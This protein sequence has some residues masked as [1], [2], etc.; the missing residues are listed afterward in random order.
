MQTK[1]YIKTVG[2]DE[3][4][5]L[6]CIAKAI[7]LANE[8]FE[9][10]KI[11]LYSYTQKNFATVIKAFD[12]E[13]VNKMFSAPRRII[14]DSKPICC[15]TER[16]YN[17]YGAKDVV[18]CCHMDSDAVF[19]IDDCVSAKY[20]IALSWTLD[21]LDEWINRWNAENID[22]NNSHQNTPTG[23]PQIAKIALKE[24][25]VRMFETKCMGHPDDIETCKTYVRVINKYI[26]ELSDDDLVDYLVTGLGWTNKEAVKVGELLKR[27]KN[28][29]RFVGGAKTGLKDY[30]Q[31][32]VDKLKNKE[33]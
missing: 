21:G 23:I 19:K 27:L 17:G 20:I 32:W 15:A 33:F 3:D 30:Y 4:A 29:G 12:E 22:D 25:D 9:I 11:V 8:D 28:G 13:T 26:P 6:R 1:Y 7:E 2:S 5:L 14:E 10:S 18:V 24:M 16:T 31:R